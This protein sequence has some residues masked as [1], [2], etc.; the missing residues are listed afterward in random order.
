MC[1]C[2]DVCVCVLNVWVRWRLNEPVC[3]LRVNCAVRVMEMWALEFSACLLITLSELEEDNRRAFGVKLKRGAVFLFPRFLGF[4]RARQQ[5][6]VSPEAES[7]SPLGYATL[8]FCLDPSNYTPDPPLFLANTHQKKKRLMSS[9][10]KL[11][12]KLHMCVFSR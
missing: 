6:E 9:S 3:H 12:G 11:T 2:V 7:L 10:F 1:R 5:R 4:W 8:Y